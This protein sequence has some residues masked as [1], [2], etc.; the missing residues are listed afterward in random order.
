MRQFSVTISAKVRDDAGVAPLCPRNTNLPAVCDSVNVQRLSNRRRDNRL[1]GI[2]R[3][4]EP[5]APVNQSEVVKEPH[6]MDIDG[7]DLTV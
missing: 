2:L 6:A 1:Q 4:L 3:A 7:K 5:H